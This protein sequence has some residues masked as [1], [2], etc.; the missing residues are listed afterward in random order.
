M[1]CNISIRAA[2]S[3]ALSPF[4]VGNCCLDKGGPKT[5]PTTPYVSF[6]PSSIAKTNPVTFSS[7]RDC[8][9]DWYWH[10]GQGCCT[11]RNPVQDNTPDPQC[12]K[13][14]FRWKKATQ[15]CEQDDDHNDNHPVTSPKPDVPRGNNG[16]KDDKD[17]KDDDKNGHKRS[18]ASDNHT[19]KRSMKSRDVTLCP[20]GFEACP[21]PGITGTDYEW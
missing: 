11:P 16:G 10:L 20:R 4:V 6:F 1:L 9:R 8:P 15:C 14:R 19:K 5:S 3:H 17:C 2:V 12:P 13:T 21:I 18:N 7:G